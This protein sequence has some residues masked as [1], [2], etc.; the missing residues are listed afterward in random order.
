MN[1]LRELNLFNYFILFKNYGSFKISMDYKNLI[2]YLADALYPLLD[3]AITLL[4]K[5]IILQLPPYFHLKNRIQM[6]L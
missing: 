6:H 2:G 1:F 4:Y 3:F 5:Y